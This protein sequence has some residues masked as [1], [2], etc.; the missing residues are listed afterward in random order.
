MYI[1]M[2]ASRQQIAGMF[3]VVLILLFLV[4]PVLAKQACAHP[5]IDFAFFYLA[6]RAA[7]ALWQE[8]D[9]RYVS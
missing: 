9:H 8:N 2:I 1:Y 5:L 4:F 3:F 7:D 6:W